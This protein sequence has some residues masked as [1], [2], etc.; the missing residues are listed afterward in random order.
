[1]N[2]PILETAGTIFFLVLDK[3]FKVID[4]MISRYDNRRLLAIKIII[5][6]KKITTTT[7]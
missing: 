3:T 7:N 4:C 5:P 2:A 1:M 6:G